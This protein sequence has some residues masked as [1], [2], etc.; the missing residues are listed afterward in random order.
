MLICPDSV[1]AL[2]QN[3]LALLERTRSL[4]MEALVETHSRLEALRAM[5]A[6][7]PLSSASMLVT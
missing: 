5:E 6:G 4:G 3:V 7:A 2:E 1:A